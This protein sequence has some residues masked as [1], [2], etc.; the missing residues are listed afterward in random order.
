[1][2]EE[3]MQYG[4]SEK[5]IDLYLA[6]LKA[7]S[8]TS[9]RIS[10]LTGI[11]R[12]TVYEVVEN[13]KKKGLITTHTQN[14]KFYFTASEPKSLIQRLKE[15]EE[16]VKK[17]LPDL[18]KISQ[19]VPEKPSVMLF[20]G[21]TSIRDALSEML[22]EKE[23]LVYGASKT[24]DDVFG[25]YTSNFARKRVEK[26]IMLKAII[27]PNVPKHMGNKDIKKYTQIK[28]L[29]MFEKHDSAYFIYGNKMIIISLGEELIAVKVNSPLL[30]KSQK[31]IF[32]FLW[33]LAR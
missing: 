10:E 28:T 19:S 18:N 22:K 24:A 8:I 25:S 32:D 7:G 3:L 26:K 33:N 21:K 30:V 2:K 27:E 5:E 1:M 16:L 23:I 4:L 20:E 17:I 11:R 6:C 14:K 12:S 31:Q 29:K 9:Q 13:L 15:K